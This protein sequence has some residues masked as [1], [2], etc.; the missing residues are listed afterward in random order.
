MHIGVGLRQELDHAEIIT[1]LPFL[2]NGPKFQN[3]RLARRNPT[4]SWQRGSH[5]RE[6][7]GKHCQRSSLLCSVTTERLP[8]AERHSKFDA[9]ASGQESYCFYP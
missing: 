1:Q 8:D 2:K 6:H 4:D 9:L 3:G 5:V 7:Q